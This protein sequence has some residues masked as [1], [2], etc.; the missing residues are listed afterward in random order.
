[1][2]VPLGVLC[3]LAAFLSAPGLHAHPLAPSLLRLE[4]VGD[5]VFAVVWKTPARGS[6]TVRPE[7]ILPPHCQERDPPAGGVEGVA[8]VTR[9]SLD[10]GARGLV[11]ERIAIGG[12]APRGAPAVIRV[13]LADGRSIQ[14]VVDA[15]DPFVVVPAAPSRA[16]V[17]RDYLGLGVGHLVF[18][19]DHVLFV[20]GLLLLVSGVRALLATVTAFTLGHSVT[21]A[22]VALGMARV[23]AA[24]VEVAIAATLVALAAEVVP[25]AAPGRRLFGRRPWRAACLFGLLHGLGFAGALS[26]IGLPAGEIPLALLAFN[27]GIELGQITWIA[28]AIGAAAL[29]SRVGLSPGG[30]GFRRSAAYGIGTLAAFWLFQRIEAALGA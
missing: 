17:L 23:P 21:L 9:W 1:M 24:W 20:L 26:E 4:A 15:S 3:V 16:A 19:L 30:P 29:L 5:G 14:A 8:R 2:R 6:A 28:A 13:R 27:V 12:L 25:R 18:G 11:G 22:I 10:C 7:P